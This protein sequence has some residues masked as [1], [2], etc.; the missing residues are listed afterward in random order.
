[1]NLYIQIVLGNKAEF[2]NNLLNDNAKISA[3]FY[4]INDD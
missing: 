2:K 4:E 3:Q 1:M